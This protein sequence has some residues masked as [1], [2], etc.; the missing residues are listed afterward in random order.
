MEES[1]YYSNMSPQKPSFNRG[2]WKQLEELIRDWAVQN[3][4][5]YIV[6]GGVLNDSLSSIGKNKVS[7]P[8]YFYKVILDYSEPSIKGIGFIMLNE[9]S[10]EQLQRYAVTIDSVES[11][12]GID[13]FY[14]LPNDQ[15]KVIEST[16]SI[17]SWNWSSSISSNMGASQIIKS[18]NS[19]K[20]CIGVTKKGIQCKNKTTN[21]NSYCYLHQDQFQLSQNKK[22]NDKKLK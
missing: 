17:K 11:F 5:I 12:T 14:Q 19:A 1:F 2:I 9:S 10:K 3:K 4:E 6:T 18:E 22:V 16:L 20:Q 8:K 21:S 13:F 7:V 15:E